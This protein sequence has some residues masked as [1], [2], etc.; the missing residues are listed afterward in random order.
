MD[1]SF[2]QA[3]L[4]VDDNTKD[5]EEAGKCLEEHGVIPLYAGNGREALKILEDRKPNAVLTA[6]HM[7]EMD[8]LHLVELMRLDHPSIP[9][10]LMTA[11]GSEAAAADALKAGALSYVPK[12]KL[13]TDL[14]NTMKIV[15]AAVE[16]KRHRERARQL[17]KHA[18]THFTLGYEID[19]PPALISHF[20]SNLQQLDFCDGTGL[21]QI[22]TALTEAINNAIEHGN[23]ELHSALRG[24]D[25]EAYERQRRKRMGKP[26]YRDRRVH[27]VERLTP[28]QV[29]YVIRDE[30]TGFDVS[31][32]PDPRNPENLLKT[33]GRGL[34]LVRLFMDEVSFNS[35]GNEITLVKRRTRE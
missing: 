2:K 30:G 28:L 18:E 35:S 13:R 34:M 3:I 24:E 26:P 16:A 17:L 5:R 6:L 21:F 20:Q 1:E 31:G 11:H 12:K 23:L 33:T 19:G 15:L 27:V 10:V 8:G 32:V 4:V 22:S 29:T 7:P 25:D 14:C 9:V